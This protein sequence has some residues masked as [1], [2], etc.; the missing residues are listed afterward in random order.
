M[1]GDTQQFAATVT[2]ANDPNVTWSV[3]GG[4]TID[5][6]T[7]LFTAG[8]TAGTFT[9]RATSVVDAGVFGEATVTVEVPSSPFLVLE[10]YA[11]AGAVHVPA[12]LTQFPLQVSASDDSSG[13][14]ANFT[15]S[16]TG[17]EIAW[18]G[19]ATS[20]DNGAGAL[21]HVLLQFTPS[22]ATTFTVSV[23]SAWVIDASG[24]TA[25]AE[26]G[27]QVQTSGGDAVAHYVVVAGKATDQRM[28][29]TVQVAAG[30]T[31]DILLEGVVG[32]GG[33]GSGDGA[34]VTIDPAP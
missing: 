13:A 4:G 11:E 20:L 2:G 16:F 15:A 3:S 18:S 26:I 27:A 30:E 25:T 9:V 17:N 8:S 6:T 32:S 12:S 10:A 31:V 24:P 5:A 14:S 19:S 22:Q 29:D 1:P 21:G 34:T 23:D 33:I 7:G 28:L